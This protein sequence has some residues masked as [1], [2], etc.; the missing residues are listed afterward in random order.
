M[1]APYATP[2]MSGPFLSRHTTFILGA[3]SSVGHFTS[4]VALGVATTS[5]TPT[6]AFALDLNLAVL[7]GRCPGSLTT[8]CL[9]LPYV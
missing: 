3:V 9:Q 6:G 5:M 4:T 7:V 2:R 1:F 8:I